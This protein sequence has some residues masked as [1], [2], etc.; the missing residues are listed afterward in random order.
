MRNSEG[1]RLR[2]EKLWDGESWKGGLV[3]LVKDGRIAALEPETPES[4]CPET[5][6]WLM[7]GL[8][9]AHCHTGLLEEA[10]PAGDDVNEMMDP[11]SPALMALDG[12]NPRE[13]AFREAL[14]EGITAV[15]VLPGS[16]C[17]LG[18]WGAALSTFGDT[19][20]SRTLSSRCGM[21]SAL[22]ENPKRDFG[23][24][25][26]PPYTRM[27]SAYLLRKA[28]EEGRSGVLEGLAGDSVRR[29][30]AGAPWRVHAHRA[31]DLETALRIAGEYGLRLVIE[32]GTEAHLLTGLL[33]EAG[34]TVV[35]GP[36]LMSRAKEEMRGLTP[37]L[38]ARLEAAGI[39]VALMTDAPE[40]PLSALRLMAILA[41][42][43]GLS[44]RGALEAV[45]AVPA[46]VL[47]LPGRGRI[48]PGAVADLALFD[49][50]PLNVYSRVK[51]VWGNGELVYEDD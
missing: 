22:G 9:E 32:H 24:A 11:V 26:R 28:L 37:S 4:P 6:G 50:D 18:G 31:D 25:G 2:P 46:D 10:A 14:A 33:K 13:P 17:L 20:E 27:G 21:K 47:E 12:I 23:K 44:E 7:P 34:V 36:V 19:L 41:R 5:P 49:G 8:I 3:L 39:P 40:Q 35:A 42:R 15:G 29:L 38:P 1:F 16:S 45:T 30:L 48:R 43:E 51:K